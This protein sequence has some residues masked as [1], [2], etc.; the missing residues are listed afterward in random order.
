[1]N[2][3][4]VMVRAAAAA[5][6]SPPGAAPVDVAVVFDL[7]DPGPRDVDI[8]VGLDLTHARASDVDVSIVLD[9]GPSG[10][11]T[12]DGDVGPGAAR[13]GEPET[14]QGGEDD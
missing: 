11:V 4:P 13:G 2:F 1:M 9:D 3:V 5:S 7:A 6:R 12:V 14:E 10:A 8:A